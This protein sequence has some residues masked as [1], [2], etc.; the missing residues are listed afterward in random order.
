MRALAVGV[1]LFAIA[2]AAHAGDF[3]GSRPLICATMQALDCLPGQEC[4]RGLPKDI[5]APAF[6]RIDFQQKQVVGPERTSPVLLMEKSEKQLMLQGHELGFGWTL[7]I[8]QE[9]GDM[10]A[11]LADRLGAVVLFGACTPL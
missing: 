3:D 2:G 1:T 10:T 6:M 5:G 8:D 7:A 11:T 4:S 9:S